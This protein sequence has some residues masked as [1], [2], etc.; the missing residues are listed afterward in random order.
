MLEKYKKKVT[1]DKQNANDNG[2]ITFQ[3]KA[4]IDR[5]DIAVTSRELI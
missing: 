3:P 2:N 5:N 1:L 4:I